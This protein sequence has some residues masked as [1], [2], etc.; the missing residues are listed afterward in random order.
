MW[1]VSNQTVMHDDD[2]D[3]D[4]EC[5]GGAHLL[6]HLLCLL[7]Q[8]DL[9]LQE[10]LVTQDDLCPQLVQSLQFCPKRNHTK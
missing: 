3:D 5:G 7:L 6:W 10:V 8:A 1:L 4:K 9:A 2:D